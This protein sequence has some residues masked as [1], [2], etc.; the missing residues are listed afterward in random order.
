MKG[1]YTQFHTNKVKNLDEMNSLW[2][3][4]RISTNSRVKIKSK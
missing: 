3:T 4:Q 1:L 2:E